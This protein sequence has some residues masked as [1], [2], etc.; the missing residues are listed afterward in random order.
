MAE[1]RAHASAG[2]REQVRA[3][4]RKNVAYQKRNYCTNVAI[5]T[6]PLVFSLI[7]YGIQFAINT[8]FD[9]DDFKCGCQC[10][11]FDYNGRTY[12]LEQHGVDGPTGRDWPEVMELSGEQ[13]RTNT[14]YRE[15]GG[16]AERCTARTTR[17]ES[18]FSRP[19]QTPWCPIQ[20]PAQVQPSLQMPLNVYRARDGVTCG[21]GHSGWPENKT[22]ERDYGV[23]GQPGNE[24]VL[25]RCPATVLVASD[26]NA[27]G[28]R[29]LYANLQT[30]TGLN[31]ASATAALS[32]AF[33]PGANATAA[34]EGAAPDLLRLM[35]SA[36]DLTAAVRRDVGQLGTPEERG[37]TRFTQDEFGLGYYWTN[38]SAIPDAAKEMLYRAATDVSGEPMFC[39]DRHVRETSGH[40][41]IRRA[42]YD[43]YGYGAMG[44]GGIKSGSAAIEQYVAAINFKRTDPSKAGGVFEPEVFYNGTSVDPDRGPG[45]PMN[46]HRDV[47]ELLNMATRAYLRGALD[48]LRGAG[49]RTPE[50]DVPARYAYTREMPKVGTKLTLEFSSFLGPL[51][52]TWLLQMLLPI[53][54]GQLVQE[55]EIRLRVIMRM[56]GLGDAAYWIIN[57][58]YWFV[59]HIV[60]TAMVLGFGHALGIGFFARNGSG[61]MYFSFVMFS[62]VQM[63]TA[64]LITSVFSNARSAST[65]AVVLL[66]AT[67]L[68][69]EFLVE[70]YIT[71]NE[72]GYFPDGALW[73]VQLFPSFG[74]YRTLWEMAQYAFLGSYT[75]TVGLTWAK[76]SDDEDCH[77]GPLL[78]VFAIEAVVITAASLYLD[79]TLATG[80]G[81]Q[82]H[83]LFP[84]HARGLLQ[85]PAAGS[86]EGGSV[87]AAA[88]AA[89]AAAA[90][91]GGG[92]PEK[93]ATL[94]E[95]SRKRTMDRGDVAE[96]RRFAESQS[97]G[98]TDCAIVMKKLC[99][100]YPPRG[101]MPPKLACDELSLALGR[102]E[103]FGLLGP[104]GAGKSTVIGMLTGLMSQTAGTAYVKGLELGLEMPEI[105]KLMGV[106][107]QH[108]LLW[109][110]LTAYEHLAFYAR[111]KR[112][113]G[114]ALEAAVTEGLR[115]VNLLDV[116]DKRVG[117]FSGGMKRRLSVAISLMGSPRVVYLDEPSTGLD[118]ASRKQLW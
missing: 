24:S 58:S 20:S 105:Y 23:P 28:K 76:V 92:D 67:G 116:R 85:P 17:C 63:A 33:R 93:A 55:K 75:N 107:P 87:D 112:L 110:T 8:I 72:Q 41:E 39:V 37:I 91:G 14:L 60:Y 101:G 97:L 78:G 59:L 21:E 49:S 42:L 61:V 5:V 44:S 40:D 62:L 114:D 106:C 30:P 96:A 48:R 47:V 103:C 45:G 36:L 18:R 7:I 12:T 19:A 56:H 90:A 65:F 117:A 38:C 98:S 74:L 111:L 54:A 102:G 43:G 32:A 73:V 9:S 68:L 34:P 79:Q 69:G 3:L 46:Y 89:A 113:D 53:M 26:A 16:L 115:S 25:P 15:S 88:V 22:L 109:P 82:K 108:D 99:M 6:T 50:G 77:I 100:V 86:R 57:L 80:G 4:L 64:L 29:A 52:Y 51:F 35:A 81:V 118:P 95:A 11:A 94:G 84:L 66:L 1:T 10:G 83:W 70:P 71:S 2:F 27:D 104:N 31:F 13:V